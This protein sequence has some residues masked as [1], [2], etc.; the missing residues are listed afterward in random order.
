MKKLLTILS[1]AILAN[2]SSYAQDEIKLSGSD[3]IA[4]VIKES[5]EKLA[6]REGLKV[7]FQMNG[8]YSAMKEFSDGKCDIA[9]IALPKGRKL[10]DNLTAIPLAYQAAYV[11][12]NSINPLEEI[13]VKILKGIFSA[14]ANPRI[15]T[16]EQINVK[17]IGMRNI[18]PAVSNN[19][20]NVS[21]ELFKY[22]AM[23]GTN[24]ASWVE[25]L[26]TYQ[27]LINTIKSNN[28]AIAI[29]SKAPNSKGMKILAI[30][31]PAKDGTEY[32]FRPDVNSIFN[33]DYPMAMPFY[34]V[35]DKKNI[36]KIKPLAKLLLENSIAEAIDKSD[37][38]SA[39]ENS[40]K[41]SVFELDITK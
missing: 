30:S 39:P 5:L 38:L 26:P 33:G 1:L 23:D 18:M 7:K 20:N 25:N 10:P 27:D 14:A 13:S 6:N 41:K 12:V 8:T 34:I 28:S 4:P 31:K 32:A 3:I 37:F 15:E 40:R 17:N 22:E 16:W 29:I 11:I 9:I 24:I 2:I 35:F 21:L 36:S 19:V